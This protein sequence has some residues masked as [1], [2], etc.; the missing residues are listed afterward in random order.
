MNDMWLAGPDHAP[1]EGYAPSSNAGQT[2][3]ARG[4]LPRGG[5]NRARNLGTLLKIDRQHKPK[6]NGANS[7]R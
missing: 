1:L 4:E 3:H 6:R 7:L 2:K 5:P